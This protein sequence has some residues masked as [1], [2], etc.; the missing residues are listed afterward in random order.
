VRPARGL[1]AAAAVLAVAACSATPADAP[2][3]VPMTVTPPP[4]QTRQEP[5]D[6]QVPTTVILMI[7]NGMGYG[8]QDL[9]TLWT[10]GTAAGQVSD[11]GGATV[12]PVPGEGTLAMQQLD[13]QRAMST[14]PV[15]STERAGGYDPASAWSDPAWVAG[16]ATD[17]AAAATAL[18]TGV[19][20]LDGM[21]GVD[22]DGEAQ[23]TIVERALA[24]GRSAG[25]VSDGPIGSPVTGAF[26]THELSAEPP[27]AITHALLTSGLSVVI[28]TGHPWYDDDHQLR[29]AP[30]W[31][32][33]SEQDWTALTSGQTPYTLI[34]S[35]DGL[36]ALAG[37][38]TPPE[39]V[40]GVVQVGSSLQAGRGGAT[41]VPDAAPHN[42]VPDL[43]TLSLA[44]LDV[45]DQ[46]PDGF[47]LVVDGGGI[48]HASHAHSTGRAIEAVEDFDAAVAAVAGW[49][50]R[51][52]AWDHTLLVVTSTDESG[53]VA[54]PG[55][56]WTAATGVAGRVPSA[57]WWSDGPVNT[58]VPFAA[59]GAGAR[60]VGA[61]A[62]RTDPVRGAY[63]DNTA[64]ARWLLHRLWA[65]DP[66]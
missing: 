8:Q 14:Y 28:G 47:V 66:G 22:P 23:E 41:D 7:G 38:P 50:T 18:A 51:Q 25:V 16:G 61:M 30:S 9:T 63:L 26:A 55:G 45:L 24:L 62:D 35:G 64:L 60:A 13:V 12:V 39:K 49:V 2:S 48:D 52:D 11:D 5:P 3:T 17:P 21:V 1:M 46:D 59:Q 34:D 32:S 65:P 44:A 36:R 31:T 53:R 37:T 54:G 42:D 20:T 43:A 27:A 10:D 33:V 56:P 40:V 58:L 57:A 29:D 15:P 19:K 4:P 6:A